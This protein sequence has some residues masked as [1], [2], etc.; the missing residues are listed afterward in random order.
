M[1]RFIKALSYHT[2]RLR[3]KSQHFDRHV[4]SV[5]AKFVKRLRLEL[6]ETKFDETKLNSILAFLTEFRDARDSI[7]EREEIPMWLLPHFMKKPA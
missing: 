1:D 3:R 6:K 7:W 2:Y 4:A 5:V